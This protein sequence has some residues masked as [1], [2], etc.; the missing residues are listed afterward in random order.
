[1]V[2]YNGH[3]HP[4]THTHRAKGPFSLLHV[5]SNL[6]KTIVFNL[7]QS[8]HRREISNNHT[9]HKIR[10]SLNH[11]SVNIVSE[12]RREYLADCH[13]TTE[14]GGHSCWSQCAPLRDKYDS[15]DVCCTAGTWR[16]LLWQTS[17]PSSPRTTTSRSAWLRAGCMTMHV[18]DKWLGLNLISVCF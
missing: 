5:W 4:H 17:W 10:N 16:G 8:M 1:M 15:A 13:N 6:T 9:E 14:A 11:F 12:V 3:T 2:L 18:N 7:R